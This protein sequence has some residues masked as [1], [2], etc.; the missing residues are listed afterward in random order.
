MNLEEWEG[1]RRRTRLMGSR[2]LF[3]TEK[4]A[5]DNMYLIPSIVMD[6][7]A[8]LVERM[9]FLTPSGVTSNT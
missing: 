2:E 1:G 8:M 3:S 5:E 7:S 4:A 6:V 9:H